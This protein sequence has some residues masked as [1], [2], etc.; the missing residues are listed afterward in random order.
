MDQDDPERRIAELERQLAA[1]KRRADLPRA[2]AD[3][4][5]ESLRFVA[6][7]PRIATWLLIC[8]YGSWAAL[9]A[10]F[11]VMF[12][13]P[14]AR[15]LGWV[16]LVVMAV[17]LTLFGVLGGRRWGWNK[18]IRICV[19]SD[20]LTDDKKPS[21]VFPFKDAK[22][23][24]W[25][26]GQQITLSGTALHLQCGPRRFVLGGR[27][28]RLGT[29]TPLQA[30]PTG[31]VDGWLQAA[32]FDEV[33]TMA[34][35]RS[36]LDVRGPA[37]DEPLRCLLYP[38]AKPMGPFEFRVKEQPAPPRLAIDL[39]ADAIR[40]IDPN[41]NALVASASRSRVTAT[42]ANYKVVDDVGSH[43]FPVLVVC[44][45]GLQPLT[46][47]CRRAWRG[48]VPIEKNKPEFMVSDADSR[49]LVEKFG[50]TANLK[51]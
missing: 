35:R 51:D 19:T 42:P 29:A 32:D 3:H 24:L 43:N 39:G 15:T 33:L 1:Q 46:I 12:A 8:T 47:Q 20:G 36:G 45:P 18:K 11:A 14:S 48:K 10:V 5:A 9:V 4:T 23:G 16:V 7:T 26:Q 38:P 17:G 28:H 40:V 25:A 22:L 2:S 37:P 13:V 41:T 49:A 50:L 44:V 34:A 31:R 27:D 21:E 6:T 30:P